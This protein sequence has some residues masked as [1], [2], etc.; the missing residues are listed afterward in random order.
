VQAVRVARLAVRDAVRAGAV[1]SAHD[2]AEGGVAVALAECCIAGGIGAQ[3]QLPAG[4]DPFA[5][6]PGCAYVVSGPE[7]ALAELGM[8]IGRVGG[9]ALAIEGTL[10][11][12]VSELG[13]EWGGGLDELV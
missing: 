9:D 13:R 5:E 10:E 4:L 6:A 3:V 1:G 8:V 2:I 11:L 12:A 7:Q